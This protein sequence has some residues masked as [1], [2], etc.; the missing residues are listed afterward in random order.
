L[1]ELHHFTLETDRLIIRPLALE[2]FDPIHAAL[3]S[4]FGDYP[5]EKRRHWLQ[6]TVMNYDALAGL[7]QPPYGERAVAL[8]AT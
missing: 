2:D 7:G 1:Y 6:W 3:N 8:K 4:A 5:V